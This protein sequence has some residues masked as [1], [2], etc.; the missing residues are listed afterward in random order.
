M[1]YRNTDIFNA[2]ADPNRRRIL[3][4]LSKQQLNVAEIAA[5]FSSSRTAIDNHIHVLIESKLIKVEKRGRA[6]FHQINPA[7]LRE[8]WDWMQ[9]YSTFWDENL[10]K[11]AQLAESED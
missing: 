2:I 8:V 5:N 6:R 3:D 1:T 9:P 4:L 7:P 10:A 11:L